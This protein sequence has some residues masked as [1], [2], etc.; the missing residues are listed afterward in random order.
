MKRC[1]LV[2]LLIFS[3]LMVPVSG[4]AIVIKQPIIDNITGGEMGGLIV[5]AEFWD[6]E[7]SNFFEQVGTWQVDPYSTDGGFAGSLSSEYY[8]FYLDQ[9]QDTFSEPGDSKGQ[10]S[11]TL[12]NNK[13]HLK[14]LTLMDEYGVNSPNI[15]FDTLHEGTISSNS[16]VNSQNGIWEILHNPQGVSVTMEESGNVYLEGFATPTQDLFSMIK[17]SFDSYLT[18]IESSPSFIFKLDTDKVTPVPIPGAL[19]LMGS[20][21]LCLL[22]VGKRKPLWR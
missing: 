18:P 10:W 17:I 7:Q 9:M 12:T 13:Y 11:L 15:V 3:F 1:H 16:T 4:Q 5:I 22:A 6:S 2:L 20:G 8:F 21:L 19:W 14:S